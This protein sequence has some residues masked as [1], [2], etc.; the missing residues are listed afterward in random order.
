MMMPVERRLLI[1]VA[2]MY[3]IDHMK[4][5]DIAGKMGINRTTV[6]KYLKRAMDAGIVQISVVNDSYEKLEAELE[7]KFGLKEVYIVSSNPDTEET[8]QYMGKA[9]LTFL[10]RVICDARV[11]G[12]AWGTA[13]AAVANN[14]AQERCNEIDADIVPLVG[15]PENIDSEFHVNT[16]CYKVANA[17]KARSHY[18]YAPAI[19]KSPEIREAITQDINYA[20]IVKYWNSLDIALV[21]IGAPVK[22][23]NLVWAGAF[24][25]ESIDELSRAGVVG[26]ICSVF[27]N[28]HGQVVTTGLSDRI[29]AIQLEKLRQLKY[30]IGIAASPEKVPAMYGAI[31]GKLINVLISDEETAKLLL[32]YQ[33]D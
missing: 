13:M 12:F 19:T 17:F 31:R 7:K 28:I 5:S 22:S 14:A 16:I 25:K 9:G 26:E 21:G 24:G 23:S 32:A 4:Q 33:R 15:G 3:Y 10:K 1:K 6:S 29:I 18:L 20:K 8:K 11:I 30:C 27:Y 2:N